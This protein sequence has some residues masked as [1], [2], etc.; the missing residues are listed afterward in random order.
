[1][2]FIFPVSDPCQDQSLHDCDPVA[3]CYSEQP[4]YFQCRCPNGFADVSTDSRFPGRKCKKLVDE[5]ALGTHECDENAKCED[6][7]DGYACQCKPGWF[8]NSPD[9]QHAPGRSCKKANLCANIQCAKEAE[10]HET[11][12]GPVCECFS[13]YVDF[14]RQHGMGAGH[15]CR[16]VINECATGKHDCS[17][18]ASCID[19]ANSFTCRCRDGFRDESPDLANRPGRVCVRALIPEPPECDV[20]DPMSCDAKKKEVCLFVNGTYKCQCAAGYDR[21]PDGRCLVINECDDQRLNDCASDADCIDQADGYTCQC[22]NGFA[23]ISPPDK[24]GRI[25]RT[26]V[27]ECA[28]PQKYH[29]D[30]DPNAVCIDTDEEYT[31]S[32]RPG[33][34]D[35]SSSF[36]RLPGRRC[37][38]AINECLDPSLNDCSENAI[39]EDAKEGYICT[40]RQGFVDASH[41][42]T[43][44]P[45]RVCRKPRQEKL[46]DVSP[47]KG[48]LIT[49]DPNEPKCGSNE[50]C[51][52]LYAACVGI[53]DCD[54]NAVCANAFDSYICQCRP[55]FIDISPDPEGKPGRICK[56]LI[57]ECATGIHNCSSFATC[58][59]ATDGYMCVC[60][61][62]YVDTSSQFQLAPGRRCSNASNECADRTLHT[63]DENAD[64]IDTPDSY[65]CQCYAG[66]VD[67]SSSANLQPGRVCTVETTCP[68]QKTDLMFLID[69]SGSI[70][71]YVFKNEVL[72]FIKEFLELFDIGLDN[73][74]VGLIQYSDQIRHEFDLSQY[75]DKA[76]VINAISQIQYLTGLTRTGAAIQHM[77]MEGF[78]ERRGARKQAS[79]VSRVGIVITDG[80]SQDNVTEPARNA[81]NSHINMFSV[82]V[83]DHVLGS[84]LEAIAGS[85]SRWFHVAK[86]KDLDTRLRS[87]IQKAACP[88]PEPKPRPPGGCNPSTQ[89][90]C[91]RTLNEVCKQVN[92]TSHC[93][94]PDGFQRH[95]STRRCGGNQCN[96]DLPTSCPDPEICMV[97]P[98][99]NYLCVCPK[100]YLRDQRSGICS[101][102]AHKSNVNA[103]LQKEPTILPSHDADCH[104]GGMKC[105]VNEECVRGTARDFHCECILGYE[106]N[107]RTGECSVPGSCDPTSPNP[108][109]IRKRE[110]CMP[111]PSGRYH[112]C[113]CAQNEKRHHVTGICLQNECASGANDCDKNARCIDTDDGYLCVCRNGYLDQSVDLVNKPGRIC[114]AERNECKDG[115]HKCSPNAICTDTVQGYICRCKPGFIDFS[116]NPQSFGGIV[117]KKI[118][119]E[120][121][122]PS[123]NTCH[124]NAICIDTADSY[125]CICKIGYTDLDELRN[126]GRNCQKE[127]RNDRCKQGNNDCDRNA[128]CIE[129]ADNDY[130]CACPSG[131]RDKSPNPNRPGRIAI[132]VIPECD[133]PTLN[134]CDSP[135]RA[136][137]TDTDEGYLCR[138]RQ[139]FLDISPNI[140]SKPG[141]LCKPLENEC[142][143][144]IDDCARD[145]G[146][147]EDTPDSYTCR[148]AINYLDVSFDRQ[149]RPGRK[150]KRLIDECQTGQNDCSLEAICTDTEDSYECACPTGY[151][152]VSPDIARKPGRRCLRRINE[153]KEGHHD[154]SPNA[155]CIDTAESFVCKCRD[156]FVDESP[157]TANRPGRLCRPALIDECRLGKHDCHENAVCQ[158]LP[159]GYA[160]HCKPEFIDQS[161]NRVALPGRLCTPR[162]TPP[163]AECRI[164]ASASSCKQELNEVCRLIDGQPK[165][166]CPINYGRDE[167]TKSCVVINECEFPQLNDCHP[168]ADCIDEPTSYTCR[169]KQGFMDISPNKKPGRVCQPHINECKLPHLNDCH[170]NAVCID[171]KDG[172]E[173]K[174]NQGYL[175]RKP[176][177]PGRLC[178]KMINECAETK[179]NSCDKNANCIDEEDGYRCECK[180]GFLDVSPS[181]TF[182][183]RACRAL[184]NECSDPKLNDCDKTAK[185]TDTTD[186]YHCECPPDSKDISPNPAFPGRVCLIFE[187]ECLTGKHDCD[188]NAICRDNEQSFTCECA[189]GFTDRSP[190]RLNRPGRV[191]VELVDE[192]ATGRHTCS[193]QAECRDLEEGY[194][195]ECKDGF[196]D[197]SPNLLTQPGRVCGTPEVCPPNHECSSAAVCEP[198]GGN[199]YE[200]TCIQ[201]YLDQSPSGKKGRI[202]VRNSPCRNP[203]LN[204]CSRNAIC[205][206]EPKGYRCECAHGYVD[207]SSDATQRGYVCEPPVATP[208]PPKHP[209]QD[210]LLND[211]HPAGTCRAT[212]N[213]TYTCE[214]LQGY[215][216]RSPDTRNKPG[217]IC[218]LTEPICLDANQNDCHPA[219]ICS[220]TE[221]EDKYTCRCRDGYIDQSPDKTNRPGRI[222]VEQINECLD[223]S[224]NDCDPIA[225][226]QDLPDGYTCRCPLNSDDRS[227]NPSRPGRKCFQQ[228]NE[229]RNPSL[230]NCSRFADCID[231][232]EGYKCRCRDGY[233]DGNPKYPGTMCIYNDVTKMTST[234]NSI[235]MIDPMITYISDNKLAVINECESANLNDCDRHAECIDLEGGYECR[236]KEP[237][238]DE[239]PPGQPGRICR[240]NE[241]SISTDNTC[242]KKFA[243]CEDLDDGYTCRCKAGYYDNSPNTQEPG[244]VCIEFQKE[245]ITTVIPQDE[246]RIDGILCGRNNY[247]ATKRNEVCVGGV[248]CMCRPGETRATPNDRCETVD[249]IPFLI[250]VLNKDAKM[251]SY[252][253]EYGNSDSAPYVEITHLFDKDIG[254]AMSSTT[255]GTRYVT[256]DVNYITHPKTINSSWPDGLLFNFSVA[257]LPTGTPIDVC[258]LWDQLAKSI[259]RT[260]GAIGGG[261]LQ[262][263]PDYDQL[264]PCRPKLP[265]GEACGV[266]ICNNEL[267]EVCIAGSICGCSH[268]EKRSSPTD[269]CRPVEAWNIV[270][271]V[272][273]KDEEKLAYTDILAN[274]R[275]TITKEFVRRFE[276][277]IGQCYPNTALASSFVT[278]E[279]NEIMDP[280]SINATWNRGILFNATVYFRKGSV[281][282]PS[283]VY[284]MLVQYISDRNNYQIGICIDLGPNAYRCECGHGYR[285]LNPSDPGRRC[286][287]NTGYNECERKEDNECSENARCIDQEH[288]YK[289]ECLPSFIDVSPKDAIAGS[290]CVLDYCSDVNFCPK[291]TTCVNQE[292]Q[293]ICDCDPGYVDIRKSEKRTQLFDQDTLCLKMRDIDE[294][295][296][297]ITNCSGVAECVDKTIGYE[298]HCPEGYVDGNPEEPGR[299]CGALLCDLCNSHGDCVHNALTNNITCVCS[300]G[301]SGEFCDVAPSKAS[302]IL[303][304][305]LAILFLLLTLCC[306]LYFCTKCIC[307]KR[308][309]LLY[310]EPF[311]YRKGAW[312]WSTLEASTSSESGA[313]FSAMSAAGHEYYP[314]IGIPRAKL[315]SGNGMMDNHQHQS[316]AV[317]RL[318]D[319]L[320]DGLRI[321]RVHLDRDND[322]YDSTSQ[323]SSEYTIREEVNRHVITD[324]TRKETKKTLTTADVHGTTAEFHVY[325]PIEVTTESHS[326]CQVGTHNSSSLLDKD[327]Q[328]RGESIAEFSIG[329]TRRDWNTAAGRNGEFSTDRDLESV[330]SD[331]TAED[332]VYDKKTSVKRSHNFEPTIGGGTERYRTE[333]TTT[334]STKGVSKY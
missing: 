331:L 268:G 12:F 278:T 281:R 90:G 30:C 251:L 317:S 190:N 275:H 147:C 297:G 270:L 80:R 123:L 114:V 66:F 81:R 288:L 234:D 197:R 41:N 61:D 129:H 185:C 11:E 283:D 115:T 111:H 289:C 98:F 276:S 173:C 250:R 1:M 58:I 69:G 104:N 169:C 186:S 5:C 277:G 242:D 282:I 91:D 299:V 138:C 14:S 229:C 137:C 284:Y 159:Q 329:N 301:W 260:N 176:E 244:R 101:S 179:L 300:D 50:V 15:V 261:P 209:C 272:M 88:S 64:C 230:N 267:G 119:N 183:G 125:K 204:N 191:C 325:P 236:C 136:I 85:P 110:K 157:D 84:E 142:A 165:C 334:K 245:K 122:N 249:Y 126:P 256:T 99:S 177:R 330:V 141:R 89:T 216:D 19:T 38:E 215:V 82:G 65:T 170:Q 108:C 121:E 31:C 42:I 130:V 29:V 17:S 133:D 309:N 171:K 163:P 175:D 120:C 26:R 219:A 36:E 77:V 320:D 187:N 195:C 241:C 139:G 109:D 298:C 196:I 287:P 47:S 318:H 8:D 124:K 113:Q 62:G 143:K 213:Q 307:F 248:K 262:V 78:S 316:L 79:D 116:P 107:L 74:R 86:F 220:E 34:A 102:N 228:V 206:D 164:D 63:C 75:T 302:I 7:L 321:P 194:T 314:E 93:V 258:N 112:L 312:P 328:E 201:G 259:Q 207:R 132:L 71:S 52:D 16:K 67:V 168:N 172:Y 178:K 154:C 274:P 103:K 193:A 106:R 239:S 210:P 27:N 286:L 246:P 56:E 205:Y 72:R 290:V 292:H 158:D 327:E 199:E 324:V 225:V 265:R 217:R 144:K 332:E 40:C 303:L 68:K 233:H 152:D 243:I 92:G 188:P 240:F 203:R 326:S 308:Q 285:D 48:A 151:I 323:S 174:C 224:L 160:C 9:R 83:T 35:I 4:G 13:G 182:R 280:M 296:L 247:C 269:V 189:P 25:C 198:L 128:R 54:K 28:E 10:C 254:H 127:K 294:C 131:Y 166:A 59:D 23:D 100:G 255:Y 271:W 310:R 192:C 221:N 161:P 145:G 24:P 153:C 231:N 322:A 181:P 73:T 305:I 96:P 33:F 214:C 266:T 53:N 167:A 257:L 155:D 51:T 117:C 135:D 295:A 293:A 94:C 70:G 46:N 232:Q 208:P 45:G 60:N 291:N 279:V 156:D 180:D 57:N 44:Y 87:L 211:C 218:I 150:C 39:C 212:G 140:T 148:C 304:V 32:C 263:A 2:L 333:I 146:I 264:N 105:G 252:S 319:Y 76:S 149:N 306:L 222:C 311:T 49:C 118:V 226:C 235:M 134:D 253:S 223:R 202:C 238:R 273:R 18:S 22:K 43:H 162:P 227:P 20:N 3:E 200:C 97:A 95:P 313:D 237:Y 21:L 315:K 184:I 37:V 6:T 55:G